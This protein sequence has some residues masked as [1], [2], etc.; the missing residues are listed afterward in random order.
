VTNTPEPAEAT[1]ASWD[2]DYERGRYLDERPVPFVDDIVAAAAAG[3]LARASGVYVGCGNGRN[4]LPL[5]AAGL[6]L[7][8]LD[9]SKAA[10]DQL[11]SRAPE[12]AGSL[13]HGDLTALAADARFALVIGIQVF[14]H[15]DGDRAHSQISAAQARVD[16]GG[17]FCL[18]VNAVGTD[19]VPAYEVVERASDGGFTVRYLAGPKEGLEIHFF[20][21]GELAALFAG[22]F[23]PVLPLR[24]HQTWRQPPEQGQWSQWEAIWRRKR[25]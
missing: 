12:R 5:V 6:D 18:R 13:V 8:G 21:E 19:V 15:G 2:A 23:E 20:S 7:I 17:L 10:L 1:A 3:G 16:V 14:Q 9:V 25:N 11:A 22:A 24:L 4:Y